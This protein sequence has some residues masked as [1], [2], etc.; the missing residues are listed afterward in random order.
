MVD[1]QR[2]AIASILSDC[3]AGGRREGDPGGGLSGIEGLTSPC[4]NNLAGAAVTAAPQEK[5][6]WPSRMIRVT[7][8]EEAR[9]TAAPEPSS[10]DQHR[11]S[12]AQTARPEGARRQQVGECGTIVGV[13]LCQ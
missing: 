4:G 6:Q 11:Q 5:Y 12:R 7:G 13:R 1:D 9:R 3:E 2:I 8:K 10:E